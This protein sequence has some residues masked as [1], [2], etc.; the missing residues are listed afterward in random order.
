MIGVFSKERRSHEQFFADSYIVAQ[1]RSG[2]TTKG[3]N[4]RHVLPIVAPVVPH[5]DCLAPSNGPQW[6]R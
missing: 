4:F 3:R 1:I 6:Q 2:R 5:D